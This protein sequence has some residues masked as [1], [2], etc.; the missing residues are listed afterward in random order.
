MFSKDFKRPRESEVDR[1]MNKRATKTCNWLLTLLQNE[2][3]S[4]V[5]RFSTHVQTCLAT[6]SVARIFFAGVKTRKVEHFLVGAR[7]VSPYLSLK[8]IAK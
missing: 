4:D 6:N 3:N 1:L 5:A 7:F 2:L 8:S